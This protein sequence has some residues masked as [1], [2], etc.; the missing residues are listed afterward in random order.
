MLG[1]GHLASHLSSNHLDRL[2]TLV[3]ELE[4]LEK[5]SQAFHESRASSSLQRK[6]KVCRADRGDF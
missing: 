2:L 1:G 3:E 5:E 6:V 4:K